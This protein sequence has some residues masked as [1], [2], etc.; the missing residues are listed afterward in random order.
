VNIVY[1]ISAGDEHGEPISIFNSPK[2]ERRNITEFQ[3]PLKK[4]ESRIDNLD[5]KYTLIHSVK[6][7][8][9][10]VALKGEN[11]MTLNPSPISNDGP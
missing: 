1:T 9:C 10:R 3:P 2:D 6:L 11:D 7:K 4:N 8:N 5:L